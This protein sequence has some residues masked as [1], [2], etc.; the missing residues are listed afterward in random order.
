MS[1]LF[2]SISLY[3]TQHTNRNAKYCFSRLMQQQET[4]QRLQSQS[5]LTPKV[6][7]QPIKSQP[8]DLTATL[9]KSNLDEL[10]LSMS[11]STMSQPDYSAIK[12]ITILTTLI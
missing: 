8:K 6:A 2:Q 1:Q 3:F 12:N 4:H 7:P 11:K 9:L 10:N 5:I